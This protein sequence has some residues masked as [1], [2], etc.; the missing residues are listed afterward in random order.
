[1]VDDEPQVRSAWQALLNAWGIECVCVASANQALDLVESGFS[2]DAIFCDQRL[3]S[4]ENG[5]ELLREL[6]TRC[7]QATG[8]MISGEFNSPELAEAEQQGYLILHKPLNPQALHRLLS[9]VLVKQPA[10]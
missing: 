7:P 9:R 4:G 8:A 5:F 3:R 2:P 1:M 10:V 6:L